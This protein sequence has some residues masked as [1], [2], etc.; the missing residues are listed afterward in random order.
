MPRSI[1]QT[2]HG[3]KLEATCIS[4]GSAAGSL[5]K[6]IA[7]SRGRTPAEKTTSGDVFMLSVPLFIELFMQIMIGNV[8][9]YML[10]PLG[11]EP[12]AAVGNSLQ[13]LNI[14]TIALS[15]MG[16]AST[17]LVTRVLG[18]SGAQKS[19]SEIAT[20][21]L[22]VN[23][24][25]AALMTVVL[26]VL[27]P[28]FFAWLHI[29]AVISGMASSFLLIVGATTVIQGAFFA[30]TAL[31]RSYA[32]VGDVMAASAIIC[33]RHHGGGGESVLLHDCQ[34]SV[35]VFHCAFTGNANCAWLPIWRWEV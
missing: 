25:L 5:R 17:V 30:M 15:A 2:L 26:F 11:A 22:V 10:A 24:V 31:L 16:T 8:N 1:A 18:G 29:D 3:S 9:Q 14:I 21:A 27:W 12:A 33:V 19:V 32:R 7:Q 4:F 28:Q 34:H 13:I 23:I 20:V 6:R 35:P